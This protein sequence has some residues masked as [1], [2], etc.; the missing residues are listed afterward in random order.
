MID[1]FDIVSLT[2]KYRLNLTFR[3]KSDKECLFK[4]NNSIENI[5]EHIF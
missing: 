3:K 5:S 2:N 4:E 1:S